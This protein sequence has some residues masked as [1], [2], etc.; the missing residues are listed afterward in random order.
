MLDTSVEAASSRMAV[1]SPV[2]EEHLEAFSCELAQLDELERT[3]FKDRLTRR[4]QREEVTSRISLG[5][6]RSFNFYCVV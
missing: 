4:A 2:E 3:I 1:P 6:Y 5:R